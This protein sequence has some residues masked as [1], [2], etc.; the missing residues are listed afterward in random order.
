MR[1]NLVNT[2]ERVQ[3]SKHPVPIGVALHVGI[4]KLVYTKVVIYDPKEKGR[5]KQ[6]WRLAGSVANFVRNNPHT[7][8]FVMFFFLKCV[9]YSSKYSTL[10][11]FTLILNFTAK[12]VNTLNSLNIFHQNIRGLTTVAVICN[13]PVWLLLCSI[14]VDCPLTSRQNI[15]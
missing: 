12:N 9:D 15:R 1:T 4:D 13:P 5:D 3:Y 14:A 2:I 8:F 11:L 10:N 7:P 6:R